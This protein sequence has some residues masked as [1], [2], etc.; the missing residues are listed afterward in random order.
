MPAPLRSSRWAAVLG[1]AAGLVGWS[2]ACSGDREPTATSTSAS[3]SGGGSGG[4]PAAGTYAAS[5]CGSCV[6]DVCADERAT[7]F[8][9]PTC[10]AYL[11][12]LDGCDVDSGGD[13]ATECEV[14]CPSPEG[15]AADAAKL[16]LDRC[17]FTGPGSEC[18]SCQVE[19]EPTHPLL[20][21][22]CPASTAPEPC[23]WCR[24]E[25]CCD[26]LERCNESPECIAFNDCR[27]ACAG[28]ALC[29][30]DCFAAHPEGAQLLGQHAACV[31]VSCP[32][33]CGFDTPCEKCTSA[34]CANSYLLCFADAG[35]YAAAICIVECDY[36]LDCDH[37]CMADVTADQL[38]K[39]DNLVECTSA[40]CSAECGP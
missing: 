9:E 29:D 2:A 28:D 36:D 33:V 32:D 8:A 25:S 31:A 18:P 24:E 17:R 21:Q 27:G 5:P 3:G 20:E 22:S 4:G 19:G 39:I 38:S 11:D 7:C 13:A 1:L 40:S 6:V 26:T 12:C 34:E 35:C 14:A 16:E 10:A 37:P 15:D 23:A 30:L